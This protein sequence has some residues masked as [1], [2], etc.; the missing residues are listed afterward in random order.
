MQARLQV[1]EL[2][3]VRASREQIERIKDSILACE[4]HGGWYVYDWQHIIVS[5]NDPNPVKVHA[6]LDA[7][8]D[9][10][11]VLG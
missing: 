2:N 10:G 8:A 4:D 11:V 6:V 7:L 3:L 5:V 9:I 1:A